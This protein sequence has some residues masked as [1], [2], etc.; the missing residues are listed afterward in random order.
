[1]MA[2]EGGGREVL[3]GLWNTGTGPYFKRTLI[4][5][6]LTRIYLLLNNANIKY[7]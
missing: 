7:L 1:M 5:A 4:F 2:F 3:G 6:K